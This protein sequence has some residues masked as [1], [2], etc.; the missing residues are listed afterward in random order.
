MDKKT[1]S[2][3]LIILAV[4]STALAV[5]DFVTADFAPLGLGAHSW[6]GVATLLG[7][8]AIYVKTS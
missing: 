4:L 3:G 5:I 1:I 8:F 2:T 6:I 7:V